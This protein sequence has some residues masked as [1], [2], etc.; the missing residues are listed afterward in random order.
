MEE[1]NEVD[2]VKEIIL[3]KKQELKPCLICEKKTTGDVCSLEHQEEWVR[4]EAE[5]EKKKEEKKEAKKE[6]KKEIRKE[7][8]VEINP[9]PK[10]EMKKSTKIMI[11][12]A[13]GLVSILL[14]VNIFWFN[15]NWSDMSEKDFN[16]TVEVNTTVN[17]DSPEIPITNNYENNNTVNVNIDLN[18]EL[19][20]IIADRVIDIINNTN[21]SA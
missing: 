5:K 19:A 7:A 9:T 12:S 10:V 8:E 6:A 15:S 14:L 3:E 13:I 4:R 17:V 20:Q 16:T 21:L 2:E 1:T 18:D 11:W